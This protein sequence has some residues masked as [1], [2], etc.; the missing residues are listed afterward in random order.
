[1]LKSNCLLRLVIPQLFE[2]EA[3]GMKAGMEV[4]K[5]ACM[6]AATASTALLVHSAGQTKDTHMWSCL[7]Q[8]MSEGWPK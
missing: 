1:M 8:I 3:G 7:S 4:V 5:K 2:M 6:S